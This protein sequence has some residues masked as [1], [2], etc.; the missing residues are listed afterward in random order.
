[1]TSNSKNKAIIFA[2]LVGATSAFSAVHSHSSEIAELIESRQASLKE[3]GG[4]MKSIRRSIRGGEADNEELVSAAT[5]LMTK[6]KE[7]PDWFP[8]GSGPD[9]GLETD[10]LSYIWE[11]EEK[12]TSAAELLITETSTL[13]ELAEAGDTTAMGKQLLQVKDACSN[14]HKSFRAD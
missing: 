1:M 8:A 7:L 13:S 11:N 5:L 10:A 4:A 9:S 2:A 14:C 6:A 12:F 3:M